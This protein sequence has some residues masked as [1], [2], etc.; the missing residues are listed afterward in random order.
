MEI[1]HAPFPRMF[2]WSEP[3]RWPD[4]ENTGCVA[5]TICVFSPALLQPST[6][7]T[8]VDPVSIISSMMIGVRP[9]TSP[10]TCVMTDSLCAGRFL[11]MMAN[12]ASR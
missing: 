4:S 11:I 10:M 8:I 3:S 6:T 9:S 5:Q 2:G 12:G 7:L 1:G